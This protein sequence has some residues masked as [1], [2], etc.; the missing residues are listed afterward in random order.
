MIFLSREPLLFLPV[1]KTIPCAKYAGL[2][3]MAAELIAVA[4][5]MATGAS[6]E[7]L[8]KAAGRRSCAVPLQITIRPSKI[9]KQDLSTLEW[10]I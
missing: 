2:K 5:F 8:A 9:M 3:S 1:G 6:V 10:L 7:T 4:F